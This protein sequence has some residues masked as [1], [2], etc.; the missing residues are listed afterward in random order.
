MIFLQI[1]TKTKNC[2]LKLRRSTADQ[3]QFKDWVE[4]TTV[5]G[6]WV[7]KHVDDIIKVA[8]PQVSAIKQDANT[9]LEIIDEYKKVL[10]H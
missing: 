1:T 6:E 3:K 2:W 4:V 9:A 10:W 8:Q 7:A 5:N